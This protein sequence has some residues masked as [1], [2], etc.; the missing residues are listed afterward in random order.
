MLFTIILSQSALASN[1]EIAVELAT[2]YMS[3]M[4]SKDWAKLPQFFDAKE[5]DMF[6]QEMQPIFRFTAP[7]QVNVREYFFGPGLTEDDVKKMPSQEFFTRM[8][9]NLMANVQSSSADV[10]GAVEENENLIHVV[11]RSKA[12]AGE[13]SVEKME[14][15]SIKKSDD[16]KSWFV[17]LNKI[18]GI[19]KQIKARM[20][21]A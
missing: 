9:A 15:I 5:L 12:M 16:G 19:G 13:V 18:K 20:G 4:Q 21:I 14:V 11:I 3:A 6:K 10:I 17:P 1:K 2:S 7:Q 8:M